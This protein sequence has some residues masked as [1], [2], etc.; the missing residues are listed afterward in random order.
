M[1]VAEPNEDVTSWPKQL[2]ELKAFSKFYIQRRQCKTKQYK[3]RSKFVQDKNTSR[4]EIHYL[5][6][7]NIKPMIVKIDNST[8]NRTVQCAKKLTIIEFKNN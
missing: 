4:D 3:I 5:K 6:S 7:I 1:E 8:I 2:L